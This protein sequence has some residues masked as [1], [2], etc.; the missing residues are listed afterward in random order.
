M[1]QQN[2]KC[3]NRA[4]NMLQKTKHFNKA[5]EK[6][7]KLITKE[8][9]AKQLATHEQNKKHKQQNGNTKAQTTKHKSL[10]T[11]NISKHKLEN[12]HLS[13]MEMEMNTQTQ[14]EH[15]GNEDESTLWWR[16]IANWHKH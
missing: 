11:N 10:S 6:C 14:V 4:Q 12:Y 1:F 15:N 7:K 5:Q 16:R 3:C 8:Q 13:A 2:E 9:N